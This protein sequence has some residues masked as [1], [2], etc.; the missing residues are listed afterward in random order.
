VNEALVREYWPGQDGVG[1]T[2]DLMGKPVQRCVV[3]GVVADSKYRVVTEAV[4]PT[5]YLPLEQNYEG[6]VTLMVRS[7]QP[8]AQVD[9]VRAAVRQLDANLPVYGVRTLEEQRMRSLSTPRM[10]AT[11]LGMLGGLGLL[12]GALGLY[13]V[14]AYLVTQRTHEIGIRMALGAERSNIL[15][16]VLGQAARLVVIGLAL[17]LAGALAATRLIRSLLYN[18]EPQDPATLVAVMLLLAAA[19]LAACLLPAHRAVR[20]DPI[21][22]LRYE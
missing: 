19:A 10:A 1:K 15:R 22:A 20:V 16:L 13:G 5:V 6:R 2:I 9:A 18:V 3:V 11:L 17:G 21:T 12:L 14:M 7:A 8:T 4:I